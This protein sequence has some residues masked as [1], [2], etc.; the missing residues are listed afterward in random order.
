MGALLTE[1]MSLDMAERSNASLWP[2]YESQ[3][4]EASWIKVASLELKLIHGCHPQGL[5]AQAQPP[6]RGAGRHPVG[7][8]P[9]VM[10]RSHGA[11]L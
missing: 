11:K 5:T 2:T 4:L 8:V 1:L 6:F 10:G 9:G 3:D 7:H